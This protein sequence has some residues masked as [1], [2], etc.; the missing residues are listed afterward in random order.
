MYSISLSFSS[1][2]QEALDASLSAFIEERGI[3][4]NLEKLEITKEEFEDLIEKARER[5]ESD[6]DEKII[7]KLHAIIMD[8]LNQQDPRINYISTLTDGTILRVASG[9]NMGVKENKE[10]IDKSEID[11]GSNFIMK[12][13][14]EF[15]D[16]LGTDI[17]YGNSNVEEKDLVLR[18]FPSPLMK[19][20]GIREQEYDE[21]NIA[22]F[23]THFPE[24]ARKAIYL[25]GS[26]EPASAA[27]EANF[28]SQETLEILFNLHPFTRL[29]YQLYLNSSSCVKTPME[30]SDFSAEEIRFIKETDILLS[31]G[32]D[33]NQNFLGISILHIIL[34][35]SPGIFNHIIHNPT[36]DIDAQDREGNTILIRACRES[37]IEHVRL[38]LN[39]D[40]ALSPVN[41][42]I[43]NYENKTALSYAIETRNLALINLLLDKGADTDANSS[44]N[45]TT[46]FADQF[47]DEIKVDGIPIEDVKDTD[48]KNPSYLLRAIELG[49]PEIVKSL[50]THGADI[51]ESY[52]NRI[53]LFKAVEDSNVEIVKIILDHYEDGKINELYNGWSVLHIAIMRENADMVDLILQYGADPNLEQGVKPRT[54]T[55]F[56]MSLKSSIKITKLLLNKG[57]DIN[58]IDEPTS[59]LLRSFI[60]TTV[61]F[62]KSALLLLHGKPNIGHFKDKIQEMLTTIKKDTKPSGSSHSR[63]KKQQVS[64]AK[65]QFQTLNDRLIKILDKNISQ[66]TPEMA[67]EFST[68]EI[69]ITSTLKNALLKRA[70]CST[71]VEI[72][73]NILIKYINEERK[74]NSIAIKKLVTSITALTQSPQKFVLLIDAIIK[75]EEDSKEPHKPFKKIIELQKEL[76]SINEASISKKQCDKFTPLVKLFMMGTSDGVF[77]PKE[78]DILL[79]MSEKL[80]PTP[81][82]GLA[83][84]AASVI[85]TSSICSSEEKEIEESSP[86]K[87]QIDDYFDVS[88]KKLYVKSKAQALKLLEA[89]EKLILENTGERFTISADTYQKFSGL[90][91]I[92]KLNSAILTDRQKEFIEQFNKFETYK[93]RFTKSYEEITQKPN[94]AIEQIKRKIG[95]NKPDDILKLS[96][97]IYDCRDIIL[98]AKENA[99]IVDF[100]AFKRSIISLN[101]QMLRA[102]QKS[103]GKF[104]L[105]NI[106]GITDTTVVIA[107][108][109]SDTPSKIK[110]DFF[111]ANLILYA[112]GHAKKNAFYKA[113]EQELGNP[114]ECTLS[115]GDRHTYLSI[116][117]KI[118]DKAFDLVGTAAGEAIL[119]ASDREI[120]PY[121]LIKFLLRNKEEFKDFVKEIPIEKQNTIEATTLET[122]S[123][124][125]VP[126]PKDVDSVA[127]TF[128]PKTIK[129]KTHRK[130]D[131]SSGSSEFDTLVVAEEPKF[132]NKSKKLLGTLQ[133]SVFK[134]VTKITIEDIKK[135]I[136][137][138][139]ESFGIY[140]EATSSGIQIVH[141]LGYEPIRTHNPHSKGSNGGCINVEC[142]TNIKKLFNN[143]GVFTFY[144]AFELAKSVAV[145]EEYDTTTPKVPLPEATLSHRMSRPTDEK[146]ITESQLIR[147][148]EYLD[149]KE[150]VKNIELIPYINGDR[151]LF[152]DEDEYEESKSVTNMIL[153][154]R[155]SAPPDPDGVIIVAPIKILHDTDTTQIPYHWIT[156]VERIKKDSKEAIIIN[157][158][159]HG[160]E[161]SIYQVTAM[162]EMTGI[163]IGHIGVRHLDYQKIDHTRDDLKDGFWVIDFIR[164]INTRAGDIK[165]AENFSEAIESYIKE[166]IDSCNPL[167]YIMNKMKEFTPPIEGSFTDS[168][169]ETLEL[170]GWTEEDSSGSYDDKIENEEVDLSGVVL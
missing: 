17:N 52:K 20:V 46:G 149:E 15:M 87:K 43:K 104:Q 26:Y 81:T 148:E 144:H 109:Y 85:S 19:L 150:K 134:T 62:E 140:C 111:S 61:S 22:L 169:G 93:D 50:I 31:K 131:A 160:Y 1:C 153:D 5:R 53:I 27:L 57:A 166:G 51:Y 158:A 90:I 142:L 145:L 91:S 21:K 139:D 10:L 168:I 47:I 76:S 155:R 122:S 114:G 29:A 73:E 138:L 84:E 78:A 116:R 157:S 74:D 96:K 14:K 117:A 28:L 129:P 11:V 135:L 128:P 16:K 105:F 108:K 8:I 165:Q 18:K 12:Q 95:E 3:P 159:G 106:P 36:I 45:H 33:I 65:L 59:P 130:S 103:K 48:N 86:I 83:S 60:D 80:L 167:P 75:Y 25:S 98:E 123:S 39:R 7:E 120:S 13:C 133:F 170:L 88:H 136:K 67:Y 94:G 42:N 23:F 71:N 64:E 126:V 121:Q 54:Q 115:E 102:K 97:E 24:Y 125:V 147:M 151:K 89:F 58:C 118:Y 162:I 55:A 143:A 44:E 77:T 164:K 92:L 110:I 49:E 146:I 119:N 156:Y 2:L 70:E 107:E 72:L 56:D 124:G 132:S 141:P 34:F 68:W 35:P 101:E 82:S 112:N 99:I 30:S 37:R 154:A 161:T 63:D 40:E 137:E 38:L 79:R 163:E 66:I 41:L 100:S 127:K 69:V 6:G 32:F 4:I 113:V 9:Y 152:S